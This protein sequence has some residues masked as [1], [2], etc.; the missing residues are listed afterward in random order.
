[1]PAVTL[2]ATLSDPA[3][4]SASEIRVMLFV[5]T[6]TMVSLLTLP[7]EARTFGRAVALT[8]NALSLAFSVA[9]AA[10]L[11]AGLP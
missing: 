3:G 4:P 1:V 7:L 9:A 5:S 2:A 6:S 11:S 8:R 10:V